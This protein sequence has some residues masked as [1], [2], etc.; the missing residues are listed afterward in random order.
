LGWQSFE[1]FIVK[2][3]PKKQINLG[4]YRDLN[5]RAMDNKTKPN[6]VYTFVTNMNMLNENNHNS[7]EEHNEY[8]NRRKTQSC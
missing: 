7:C 6:E 1:N 2:A 5:P 4:L 3:W 8:Q